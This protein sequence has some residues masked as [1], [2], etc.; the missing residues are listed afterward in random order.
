M[1]K[2]KLDP[3]G[4]FNKSIKKIGKD[5]SDLTIPLLQIKKQWYQ[6]NKSIFLLRGPGKYETLDPKYQV[7]KSSEL[8]FVYPLLRGR[9]RNIEAAI[10]NA[11]DKHAFSEITKKSIELGVV[12]SSD[13]PYALAIHYGLPEKNIKARPYVLLG[14]EQVATKEQKEKTK[15]YIE[16][17]KDYVLQV[18]NK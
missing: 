5:V 18:S 3:Q 6:G 7:R 1:I 16:I 11:E 12:K 9:D 14:V 10:T 17:L 15:V 4:Q 13:F 2:I 8:G